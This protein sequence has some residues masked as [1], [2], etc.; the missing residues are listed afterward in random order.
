MVSVMGV[1]GLPRH[2][3][4]RSVVE[5]DDEVAGLDPGA[6][7]RRVVYGRDHLDESILHAHFDAEAAELALGADLQLLERFLVQVGGVRI[8]AG[9]HAVDG[10]GD[11]L[12]VLDRLDIVALDPAEDLGE[13]AQLFYRQRQGRR[14]LLRHRGIIEADRHADQDACSDQTELPKLS[15]HC[16]LLENPRGNSG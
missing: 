9:Q 13:G 5:L 3:L 15:A 6:R 10:L 8:E 4:D 2:A 7:R 12:L 11:E 1:L 16:L 14:A